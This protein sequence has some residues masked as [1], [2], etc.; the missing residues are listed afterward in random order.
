MCVLSNSSFS[1]WWLSLTPLAIISSV[2]SIAFALGLCS[3]R[4]VKDHMEIDSGTKNK[5]EV[6][7][8]RMTG[9]SVLVLA[10]QLTQICLRFY[11]ADNQIEWEKNYYG[12]NCD[13]LFVPCLDDGVVTQN[14]PSTLFIVS[15]YLI[16]LMPALAP[17]T[18]IAN[19]KSF[20]QKYT[21][22]L[23]M[24]LRK[25]PTRLG[26]QFRLIDND[27]ILVCKVAFN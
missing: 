2:G 23:K 14:T 4:S 6:F 25:N 7:V 18:W 24:H 21:I 11:E 1:R 20:V 5:L 12:K 16:L 10:P 22:V 13:D 27:I 15:R 17:L 9:F 3:L 8:M 19:R 26:L